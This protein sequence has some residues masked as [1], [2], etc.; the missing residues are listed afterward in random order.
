M[1]NNTPPQ[2]TNLSA[3]KYAEKLKLQVNEL[4]D[5]LRSQRDILKQKG[6]NLPSGSLDNLRTLKARIDSVSKQLDSAFVE[7]Q[8]LRALADTTALINSALSTDAV[9]NRV[10]D[11]VIELTGAE[12]GYIVLKSRHTGEL[13]QFRVA[14]GFTLDDG[15]FGLS[16]AM[17]GD[18]PSESSGKN[19]EF[20]VSRSII[21]EVARTGQPILTD[22]A[23]ESGPW[24]NQQSI[25]NFALRS[26]LAVPLEVRGE[27]IG[28]VYCDNRIMAGLFRDVERDMLVA[29]ADQAAVA[30]ENARLFETIRAQLEQ[31]TEIRDLMN[32]I[33]ESIISGVV[34]VNNDGYVVIANSAANEILGVQDATG[35]H[36]QQVMPPLD[37][38]FYDILTDIMHGGKQ[39]A[40]EVEP[41]VQG[42]GGRNWNIIVSPLQNEQGIALVIDDLTEQKAR[43]SQLAEVSRFLP[44]ALIENIRSIEDLNI[45]GQERTI[46]MIATDVRGFTRFSENLQPEE[47]MTIIN[48]YLSVASDGINLHNGIVDKYMG[49]AV[50]GLFNTQLNPQEDDHAVRAVRA[51][52]NIIYDLHALHEVLPESQRLFFGIGIHTGSAYLGNV[53]S[54]DRKEFSALGDAYTI[55]KILES[56][57]GPGEVLISPNTYEHIKDLFECEPV[58]P[59]KNKGREDLTLAYKVVR[60][61]KGITTGAL[62]LDPEI[63]ELLKDM[64]NN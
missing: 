64:G 26:I 50:T 34:T 22:N 13:D 8:S 19:N 40:L 21:N 60:R 37:N 30:I 42:K 46:T 62:V 48:Q 25:V 54:P 10:M 18:E 63:A 52:M 2:A 7:L 28:V 14:R 36:L 35:M 24:K 57:A 44:L 43:E 59:E 38:I 53:G 47:L 31:I 49:D 39:Q 27:F 15:T 29:F 4:T 56:N 33:F 55:S 1:L 23:S 16:A 32:N 58:V 3:A 11:K 51:A 5:L 20:I 41:F 6:M 9:L 17:R 61:K 45:S 12:R